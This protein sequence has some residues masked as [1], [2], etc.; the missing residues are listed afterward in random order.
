MATDELINNLYAKFNAM[1]Q[2]YYIEGFIF[3]F[4]EP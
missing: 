3:S 4:L 2:V 1:N